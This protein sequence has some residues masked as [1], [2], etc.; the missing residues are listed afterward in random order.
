[1]GASQ[2]EAGEQEELPLQIDLQHVHNL[3]RKF[4]TLTVLCSNRLHEA[5]SLLLSFAYSLFNDAVIRLKYTAPKKLVSNTLERTYL[6]VILTSFEG[7]NFIAHSVHI[8]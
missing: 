1:V 6:E 2:C 5:N 4:V 3:Q 8:Q 7:K